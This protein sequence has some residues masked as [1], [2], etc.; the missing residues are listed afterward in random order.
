MS[1][2]NRPG[3]F[4]SDQSAK[5]TSTHQCTRVRGNAQSG[6]GWNATALTGPG[7]ALV[8]RVNKDLAYM[9]T[10]REV[11]ADERRLYSQIK[12][13]KEL[14][15]RIGRLHQG[16]SDQMSLFDTGIRISPTLCLSPRCFSDRTPQSLGL[17]PE[18]LDTHIHL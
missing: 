12:I 14:R 9:R 17:C 8:R 15:P 10:C 3:W 4:D 11:V 7:G 2:G 5:G 13:V 1:S 16:V 18:A 6:A